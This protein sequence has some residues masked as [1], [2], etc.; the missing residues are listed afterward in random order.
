MTG[1]HLV[2][3][4]E[5]IW[6]RKNL[7]DRIA[8]VQP[9][10]GLSDADRALLGGLAEIMTYSADPTEIICNIYEHA[11]KLDRSNPTAVMKTLCGLDRCYEI[12]IDAG[13]DRFQPLRREMQA[14]LRRFTATALR[15]LTRTMLSTDDDERAE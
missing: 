4:E 5:Q 10:M 1:L 2:T 12:L 9:N 13:Y 3:N 14:G 11:K 8:E 15:S 6:Q 7:W